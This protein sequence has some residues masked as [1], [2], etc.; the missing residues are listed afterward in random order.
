M[1]KKKKKNSER[2]HLFIFHIFHVILF[3]RFFSIEINKILFAVYYYNRFNVVR[4]LFLANLLSYKRHIWEFN[5]YLYSCRYS[6][7]LQPSRYTYSF[8]STALFFL[9]CDIENKKKK[10]QQQVNPAIW[11]ISIWQID[12]YDRSVGFSLVWH[13][14][15]LSRNRFFA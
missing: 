14:R 6:Y 3:E 10:K 12:Q 11:M 15:I 7:D 5:N 1:G 9:N 2:L 4:N 13:C 8:G